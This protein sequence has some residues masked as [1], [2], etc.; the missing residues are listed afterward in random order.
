[1]QRRASNSGII[2]VVGQEVALGRQYIGKTVTVLV[3]ETTLTVEL[4]GNETT[5]IRRT[6][7][8]PVRGILGQRPR[9]ATNS[10]S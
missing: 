7:D 4:G 5:I 9:S 2:Q 3:S 8:Q 6:N 10:V 1:M